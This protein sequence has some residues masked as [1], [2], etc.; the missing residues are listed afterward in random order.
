MIRILS[1]AGLAV[2]LSSAASAQ[3]T[4]RDLAVVGRA[5]V[6]VGAI[7]PT[8]CIGATEI[9]GVTA[10][11]I[12]SGVTLNGQL[13]PLGQSVSGVDAAL[14]VGGAAGDAGAVQAA[15]SAGV[16]TVSTDMTCVQAGNCVMGVQSEPA[17]RI[18]VNSAAA[19]SASVSFSTAFAMMV[20]EI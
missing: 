2:L 4:E 20:E 7:V 14:F 3:T 12:I 8:F 16:M 6:D 15:T 10:A 1:A 19:S 9:H 11:T 17:V 18:V 13:V 5:L